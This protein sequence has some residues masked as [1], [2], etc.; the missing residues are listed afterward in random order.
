[1]TARWTNTRFRCG[2]LLLC[3]LL[4]VTALPGQ[5][6]PV[7][8]FLTIGP[9]PTPL[10]VWNDARNAAGQT[11]ALS[12]L[13]S[14]PHLD[15]RDWWPADGQ[16]IRAFG[17]PTRFRTLP[18]GTPLG[19]VSDQPRVAWLAFY[20]ETDR[21]D[22]I[23]IGLKSPALFDVTVNGTSLWRKT[24]ADTSLQTRDI[25]LQQGKHLV[26]I[27]TVA[28]A[29]SDHPWS[30]NGTVE[31]KRHSPRV[32]LGARRAMSLGLLLDGAIVN[33]VSLNSDGT[34][35]ALTYSKLSE[36]W[37]R[38]VRVS[39]GATVRTFS[40]SMAIS[41]LQWAPDPRR[42][43]YTERNQGNATV[44]LVNL[45]TGENTA[46]ARG[47]QRMGFTR[48]ARDGQ[49][50]Y[51]SQTE[52]PD[53]D[54][55]GFK[56]LE[57]PNDRWP[58]F[59]TRSHLSELHLDGTI[60]RLTWGPE[61]V[62]LLDE[63]P[64]GTRLLISR[65]RNIPLER[66]FSESEIGTLDLTTLRYDS[67]F[68]A[69]NT[70]AMLYSPDGQRLLVSG[71][72]AAFNGAGNPLP[73]GVIPNDYDTQLYLYTVSTGVVTPITR[74]FDPSISAAQWS[75]DGA[76]IY[77][78][79]G[80]KAFVNAYRY[81]L[82]RGTFTKLETGVDI[83]G[84]LSISR[85]GT[86]IAYIGNGANQPPKA[87]V[88]DPSRNRFRVLDDPGADRYRDVRYGDVQPWT[89]RNAEGTEIDGH[90]YYPVNFDASKKYPV[91]V[92]YYG[93]TNPVTRDFG[94]RYPK[95]IWAANG[96][97]VY[98]LQPSGATGY[99]AAFAAAHVN[100]WGITVAD[101]IIQGTREF[102]A[103]HPFADADRVGA[104]GASY[105]GFMTMLLATRT[106]I[107]KTGISH[108][109]I[110]NITSYWGE[111]YWGWLYSSAATAESFPWNR[112]DIYV[113]QS[114]IFAADKVNMPLLLLHGAADTNV[115]LGESWQFYT[116]LKV[117]GKDVELIEVADQD[118][119]IVNPTKRMKWSQT[120]MAWFDKHLKDQPEWWDA[121]Y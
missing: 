19:G 4:P 89:F 2:F 35:A 82:R 27:K 15:T 110:S 5:P 62:N 98:V 106:D 104:I 93:G 44:W 26:L 54:T 94:G 109:G 91:I 33:S 20:I 74:S 113:D 52:Q 59:R 108:A 112:R 47:I 60:R 107:F 100:N 117:L 16:S 34:L 96:Y 25:A 24:S 70:G 1:M 48:W 9:Y 121:M 23:T 71:S 77:L 8:A 36:T 92:Y 11:F 32:T 31:A 38:I 57:H 61:S 58:Q 53:T 49:R 105:G 28:D 120:I 103:T 42:F 3:F 29:A 41:G 95:E 22:E 102:L 97:M 50:I 21:Y 10:P 83:T 14:H 111:G 65:S 79:A 39:D 75:H 45:E 116:A 78:T 90:V 68:T 13:L 118:H 87:Y 101:E 76:H 17:Q 46:L 115:P 84:T 86:Q 56:L 51:F 30:F 43:L 88:L 12:Q 72:A 37:I 81:E 119:H 66:P 73:E 55:S 18:A 114:P 80:D 7:D 99:G 67:L 40:G 69:R 85:T 6:S 63:H 64:S